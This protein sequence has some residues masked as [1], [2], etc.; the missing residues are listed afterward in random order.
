MASKSP[1]ISLNKKGALK[2]PPRN[3]VEVELPD[4][5][6]V[7][8]G[9]IPIEV[10]GVLRIE[11]AIPSRAGDSFEKVVIAIK[12]ILEFDASTVQRHHNI[13]RIGGFP[14]KIPQW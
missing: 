14:R 1:V 11:D 4:R 13:R 6:F 2:S 10:A 8:A 3:L 7:R 5:Q 9:T 12:Q